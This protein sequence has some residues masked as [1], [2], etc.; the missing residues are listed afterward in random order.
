[1]FLHKLNFLSRTLPGIGPLLL[2]ID[3]I[4]NLEF[5]P[6][7]TGRPPASSEERN[8][9]A[10]PARHG[11]LGFRHLAHSSESEFNASCRVDGPIVSNVKSRDQDVNFEDI[12]AAQHLAKSSISRLKREDLSLKAEAIK[13][14]PP[15]FEAGNVFSK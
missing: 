13:A 9:L 6:K 3:N 14:I 8:L 5:I 2:P 7:L 12:L 1:M 4:I 15:F 11:G 10:L